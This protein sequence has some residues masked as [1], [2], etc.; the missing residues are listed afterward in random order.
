[1]RFRQISQVQI[2]HFFVAVG[3]K[4]HEMKYRTPLSPSKIPPL[5][6]IAPGVPSEEARPPNQKLLPPE[7]SSPLPIGFP[8][9]LSSMSPTNSQQPSPVK[10]VSKK[11]KNSLNQTLARPHPRKRFLVLL[12]S[13][14]DTSLHSSSKVHLGML[15]PARGGRSVTPAKPSHRKM[16]QRRR[17]RHGHLQGSG[18]I[19]LGVPT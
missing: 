11:T 13:N 10:N 6:H 17:F 2:I 4:N 14:T 7:S 15:S 18:K 3:T 19:R 5:R 8:P 12:T 16:S 1:M 9:Y